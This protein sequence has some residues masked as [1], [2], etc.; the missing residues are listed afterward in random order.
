MEYDCNLRNVHDK[1]ADGKTA[2]ETRCGVAYYGPLIPF[3]SKVSHKPIF[4]SWFLSDV[5]E[6]AGQAMCSSLTAKTWK[7]VS[8]RIVRHERGRVLSFPCGDGSLK[9]T[10]AKTSSK[11]NKKKRKTHPSKKKTENTLKSMSGVTSKYRHHEVYRSKLYV[12]SKH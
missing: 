3:G 12:P 6:E 7:F 8:I 5:R 4:S 10:V 2:H 1:M 9:L 11:T